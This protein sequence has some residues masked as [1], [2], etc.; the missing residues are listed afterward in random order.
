[1]FGQCVDLFGLPDVA[2]MGRNFCAARLK[3]RC[4]LRNVVCRPNHLQRCGLVNDLTNIGD[5]DPSTILRQSASNRG[6]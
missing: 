1:M 3:F 6:A 2:C 5:N 4:H